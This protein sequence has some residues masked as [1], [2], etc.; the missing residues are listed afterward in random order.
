MSTGKK[1]IFNIG[2]LRR[3]SQIAAFVLF[4]GLFITIFSAI[5]E[6]YTAV[7]TGSFSV[8]ALAQP[9]F[10]LLAVIPIT[11]LWGRFFCGFLCAF[12]SMGDFFWAIS[13][14][15]FK[16]RIRIGEKA[17]CSLKY[18]KYAVLLLVVVFG[19]T[20]SLSVDSTMS[21]WT[22]FG[23]YAS[24]T[25][26]PSAGYLL[27]VGG[28]LLLLII[29]GSMLIE[30]FFCRY[31][32]PLGAVFALISKFRLFQIKK[33]RSSCG[34]CRLCTRHCSMGIP[35]Y[36][37]DVVTSGECIDCFACLSGC[38]RHN[39]TANPAPPIAAAV[40][41]AAMTGLCYAGSL[42][43]Q[44]LGDT[45]A[46]GTG[47]A[48]VT[49]AATVA[50]GQYEDGVYTGSAS[51]FKGETTVQVTVEN[52]YISDITVLS[53]GDDE[54]FFSKA[55]TTVINDILSSQ[56]T[57]A[58][59]V[60]GATFSSD[61]I[62]NAVKNALGDSGESSLSTSETTA[63][64]DVSE[65]DVT[66]DAT[67]KSVT[68]TELSDGVY[69]G[70]GTGFRGETTV[71]VTVSG[72]EITDITVES[73]RDDA[74][75][76]ERAESTV[77]ANILEEQSVDVDTVTGATFSSNGIMEAV[78]DALGITYENQNSTLES[79]GHGGARLR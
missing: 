4:P 14:K 70:T 23:M 43:P 31:F 32:C 47:T 50:D 34:S 64:Q 56:S 73:Y 11:I 68:V 48:A 28:L 19:W 35:L 75:Y 39:V 17:D 12:G 18:L 42:M 37:D 58:D 78:A 15:L 36:Q 20:L 55:E 63:V 60:T 69:T 66:S 38:P 52:G 10:I 33:P 49:L 5:R 40:S 74:Q 51:G 6:V 21:P 65:S 3:A 67:A 8:T 72:G 46:S 13:Q 30:R 77:I 54:A 27:S 44:I 76:F 41:V 61:A 2:H 59:T 45:G 53:T 9:L 71:S 62:I 79:H 29:V 24:V 57:Q 1:K 7:L 22:I 26:W 16:K 25:G